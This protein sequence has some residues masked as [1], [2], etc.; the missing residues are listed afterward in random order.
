M[1]LPP[2]THF[3]D[4]EGVRGALTQGIPLGEDFY[5]RFQE[6]DLETKI[7]DDP[8]R[9]GI[10]ELTYCEGLYRGHKALGHPVLYPDVTI[11]EMLAD[12]TDL[13]LTAEFPD[14]PHEVLWIAFP[15][16]FDVEIGVE[17]RRCSGCYVARHRREGAWFFYLYAPSRRSFEQSSWHRFTLMPGRPLESYLGDVV[18]ELDDDAVITRREGNPYYGAQ[19]RVTRLL[20]GLLQYMECSNADVEES[21]PEDRERDFDERHGRK[22]NKNKGRAGHERRRLDMFGH[23]T[24]VYVGRKVGRSAGGRS[25]REAASSSSRRMHLVR[26]HRR[27]QACGPGRRDR[28]WIFVPPHVRGQGDVT[29]LEGLG[30]VTYR[31]KGGG[32]R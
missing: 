10:V 5:E 9:R 17:G 8:L 29:D 4:W 30:A 32:G 23:S 25:F 16:G 20:F 15:Q 28:R 19:A 14:L 24:V 2:R 27:H 7:P 12:H 11:A 6:L 31:F 1:F 18:T 13:D 22:K 21:T 3:T 26:G